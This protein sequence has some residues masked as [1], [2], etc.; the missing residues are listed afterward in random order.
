MKRKLDPIRTSDR[1]PPRSLLSSSVNELLP[2]SAEGRFAPTLNMPIHTRPAVLDSPNRMTETPIYSAISP[3]SA[4]FQHM[5]AEHRSP[6]E[7]SD[8]DRS[9]RLRRRNNSDDATSTQ[10]SYDYTGAD[11]MEIDETS[12][13][14]RLHIDDAYAAGQKRRAAS[15]APE[16][17]M[18]H[19]VSPADMTRRQG[20]TRGSPT[21]RLTLVPHPS[22]SA[23][24][25]TVA[26]RSNSYMSTASIAPS[27][28]TTANSYGRRSPG[29]VSPGGVSPTSAS[30]PYM[31]PASLNP[32]PRGSISSRVPT[33]TR[34]T[35]ATS[36]KRM[37]EMKPSKLQEFY[38]C[39]C[40]PKKPKK[41]ESLD[42]LK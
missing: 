18:M 39:D 41:F 3:R 21:P 40:C 22:S 35:S 30:S 27:S 19:G 16:D 7:S 17:H 29:G 15:P 28:I 32:S 10:G 34:N 20:L 8:L 33:H 12:S 2:R 5:P 24:F 14:K 1:S 38:M 25:S 11:D 23:S 4:P 37:T 36:P 9:P 13:L 42:Q 6:G 31:T 26:S